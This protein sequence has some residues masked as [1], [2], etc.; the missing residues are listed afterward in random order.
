V[1]VYAATSH[2]RKNKQASAVVP[3][4]V[5]ILNRQKHQS[6]YYDMEILPA[7]LGALAEIGPPAQDAVEQ[8]E[9]VRKDPNPSVGRMA[10]EALSRIRGQTRP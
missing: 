8:L 5:E 1:R 9:L 10:S 3:V 2:W 6:Y 7:A 4:L